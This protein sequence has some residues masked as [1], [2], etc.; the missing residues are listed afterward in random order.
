MPP[1]LEPG[2]YTS[3]TTADQ[4]ALQFAEY[5]LWYCSG[6]SFKV[7]RAEF[8]TS[9][10]ADFS[11]DFDATCGNSGTVHGHF[12]YWD[13]ELKAGT[14]ATVTGM[15]WDDANH[16]GIREPGELPISGARVELRETPAYPQ[17]VPATRTDAEGNY[18]ITYSP[19]MHSLLVSAPERYVS[20]LFKTGDPTLDNDMKP[21]PARGTGVTDAAFLAAGSLTANIDAGFYNDSNTVKGVVWNDLN[22]NGIRD[23]GEPGVAGIALQLDDGIAAPRSGQSDANGNYAIEAP[24]GHY[25]LRIVPGLSTN[26]DGMFAYRAT[27]SHAG[28]NPGI[29]SDFDPATWTTT[30]DLPGAGA[31]VTGHDGGLVALPGGAAGFVFLD[32]NRNGIRDAGDQGLEGI[33]VSLLRNFAV[34]ATTITDASG[35]YAF[36]YPAGLYQVRFDS[37]GATY[38]PTDMNV[39]SDRTI[40]SD[41]STYSLTT[42]RF[43]SPDANG[44]QATAN[45]GFMLNRTATIRGRVWNDLNGDGV[46]DGDEPGVANAQLQATLNGFLT[47]Q[48]VQTDASGN[49]VLEVPEGHNYGVYFPIA[50]PAGFSG[51]PGISP[52][53]VNG[54]NDSDFNPGTRLTTETFLSADKAVRKDLG[55]ID[56]ARAVL[57]AEDYA[58]FPAGATWSYNV[59]AGVVRTYSVQP[60]ISLNGSTVT[61]VLRDDGEV[62]YYGSTSTGTMGYKTIGTSAGGIPMEILYVPPITELPAQFAASGSFSSVSGALVKITRNGKTQTYSATMTYTTTFQGFSTYGT[63]FGDFQTV[64]DVTTGILNIATLGATS[65]TGTTVYSRGIGEISY[66]GQTTGS[67]KAIVAAHVDTDGDGINDYQDN[68]PKIANANQS[69][70]DG[71]GAGDV[72]DLDRDDDNVLDTAD[73]CPLVANADQADSDGDGIGNACDPD[74]DNDGMPDVYEQAHGLNPNDAADATADNDADGVSNFVEYL[75]GTDPASNASVPTVKSLVLLGSGAG[76]QGRSPVLNPLELVANGASTKTFDITV[77]VS[78]NA[79]LAG[80]TVDQRA[81]HPAW[82]DVDGDGRKELVLG[83]GKGSKG[84]IEVRDDAAAG[85]AHLAWLQAPNWAPYYAANGE[86]FPACGDLDGDGKDELVFGYGPGSGGWVWVVDDAAHN[87]APLATPI[88]GG[89]LRGTYGSYNTA[90]GASY[91]AVGDLDGD[92][93]AEIVLGGGKGRGGWLQAIDD[94]VA[95]FGFMATRDTLGWIPAGTASY[96]TADGSVWPATC[97]LSG[98]GKAEIVAGTGAGVQ[99]LDPANANAGSSIAPVAGSWLATPIADAAN[100]KETHPACGNLYGDAKAELVVGSGGTVVDGRIDVYAIAGTQL[101]KL[102]TTTAS[103]AGTWA[104]EWPA[105]GGELPVDTDGDGVP[106]A[107]DAFPNDPSESLDTDHDGVGD[108]ADTDDDN[109]G[110]SDVYELAHGLDPKSADGRNGAGGD[111]DGDDLTNAQE[112]TLGTAPELADTDGDGMTDGWE[113]AH[114]LNPLANDANLD[115]DGDGATNLEEFRGNSDPQNAVS[116]PFAPPLVAIGTGA[117]GNGVVEV[118]SADPASTAKVTVTLDV[119]SNPDLANYAVGARETRPA[120]CDV[121][122]DGA[123]ELVIGLGK[124]GRGWLEVKASAQQ[125]FAHLRWIRPGAWDSYYI[126]NG[127]TFPACGDVDGDGRE[128]IVVGFGT[129]GGGWSYVFDD[130]SANYAPMATPQGSGW[131]WRQWA[132]YNAA[133]GEIHPA[134]GDLDGDGK[135]EIVLGGAAGNAGWVMIFDDAGNGF[136]QVPTNYGGGWARGEW[137]W[138]AAVNGTVWPAVCDRGDD[139]NQLVLGYGPQSQGWMTALDPNTAYRA[140]TRTPSG[141]AWF[142][143]SD[144]AYNQANGETR[145]SCGRNRGVIDGQLAIGRGAGGA[146]KVEMGRASNAPATTGIIQATNVGNGNTWTAYDT[147]PVSH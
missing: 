132:T 9:N 71:D 40:D 49:Y 47:S 140:S 42:E 138:Y 85:Y 147:G 31:D 52:R 15:V 38:K 27:S 11:V 26:Q 97:D 110:M 145:L 55:L 57:R 34:I 129:G 56:P 115:S 1:K 25:T 10:I 70:T 136:G 118:R 105:I 137:A 28:N 18:S 122:G 128:E 91:P 84:W 111:F 113:N 41:I 19:G 139:A 104:G 131:L 23:S 94:A 135:A 100:Y 101:T 125:G 83:F 121:D 120:F 75:A 46:Q 21:G 65:I 66:Q 80:Y 2:D 33:T 76:G 77:D 88:G 64:T 69:D 95:G 116:K 68:C 36:D 63:P 6:T 117:G 144:A 74:A 45:A 50:T 14:A 109:D 114:G 54:Y 142:Q 93:R 4:P 20:T 59:G 89:W 78:T 13:D 24:A 53:A 127:E 134:V 17:F 141:T 130:A 126:A 5:P 82:C 32:L 112:Q 106:D 61:P 30:V 124:G 60:P 22:R 72:C 3:G 86:S 108:N 81:V 16:N 98:D 92:G 39:G 119:A 102:V 43:S 29:D 62:G 73:N 133:N 143:A 123:K 35:R 107:V 96:D 87:Y 37:P 79:D 103:G 67:T 8:V 146:G 7:L 90:N 12:E 48:Y 51:S 99:I 44:A 58:P